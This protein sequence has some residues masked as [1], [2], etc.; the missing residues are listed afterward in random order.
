MNHGGQ[1]ATLDFAL[2]RPASEGQRFVR[3]RE[4]DVGRRETCAAGSALADSASG[5]ISFSKRTPAQHRRVS[6]PRECFFIGLERFPTNQKL[7]SR[8]RLALGGR[9]L[10]DTKP[11][12]SPTRSHSGSKQSVESRPR[13]VY[14]TPAGRMLNGTIESVLD[15]GLCSEIESQ[16]QL[17]FTSPP[18]PLSRQKKYGNLQ[19]SDYVDWLAGLAPRLTS[20]LTPT[21][22]IVIE[23]G[24]VWVP[25]EPTMST[26]PLESLLEFLTRGELKLCQAFVWNNPARLPSP[27]QWVNI[28]RIRIKDAFTHIWWMSQ[29]DRP[30]ADN[31]RVLKEYSQSMLNLLKSG[32]YNDGHRPSE[33]HIGEKSFLKDNGGAIPSNVLTFSN[34]A[35]NNDVYLDYCREQNI[36]VHPARMP[37]DVAAFFIS[38][39]TDEEDLVFDPF[40][41][42]NTTGAVAEALG[43]QWRAVEPDPAYIKGSIG[44]FPGAQLEP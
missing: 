31:R 2:H 14:T 5:P 34:T 35:S 43:R 33:H 17:V 28:E 6:C 4:S 41:G 27:A 38:F 25:G 36:S 32:S 11:L 8:N 23:L 21:G 42:S 10:S 18:F 12:R 29:T 7:F 16:V 9:A 37:R 15:A 26:R 3:Q 13:T 24:N 44:R 19:G 30:K 20:L 1:L 40:A 39:L 22:S